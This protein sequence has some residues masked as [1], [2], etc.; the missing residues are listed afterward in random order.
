MR[1]L[2]GTPLALARS[3]SARARRRRDRP[4]AVRARFARVPG[5]RDETR[6]AV[7]DADAPVVPPPASSSD[8]RA[9]SRRD[10]LRLASAMAF[11]ASTGRA[12]PA[13]AA[14]GA[15]T[16]PS[17]AASSSSAGAGASSSPSAS[18][19]LYK[20][21]FRERFETSIS[22]GTHDYSFS[23]PSETWKP[24]IVSL[25]DG[26]L[27]GVDLRFSSPTE[28]KVA[29]HVLPFIDESLRSVG[30]PEQAL[31]RF[32]EL[33]GAFWDENGFGVPGGNAGTL[34]ST[35]VRVKDGVTYYEYETEKPRN[36]IAAAATD[37]ELYIINAGATERQWANGEANLRGIVGSFYVPP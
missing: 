18:L 13:L 7:D 8:P 19:S 2:A 33:V 36:L 29:T 34:K 16:A 31:D 12:D 17:G 32:V 35:N 4:R 14:Y 28:G 9:F 22:S 23:Y 11:G 5:A 26:K 10:G 25:N 6:A 20:R 1:S 15:Q 21:S 27:Y 3:R 24:D 37:G 30:T